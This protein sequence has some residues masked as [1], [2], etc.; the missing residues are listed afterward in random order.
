MDDALARVM[1]DRL[2]RYRGGIEPEPANDGK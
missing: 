2:A 1:V